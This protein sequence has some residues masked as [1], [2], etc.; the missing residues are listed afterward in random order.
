MSSMITIDVFEQM[1]F[2]KKTFVTNLYYVTSKSIITDIDDDG[3]CRINR[4]MVSDI[5]KDLKSYLESLEINYGILMKL[6]YS[7]VVTSEPIEVD[8]LIWKLSCGWEIIDP[9][10]NV[11]LRKRSINELQDINSFLE[12]K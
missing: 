2:N 9:S 8:N 5:F 7:I 1:F 12:S 6:D 3:F 4:N 10:K 11:T